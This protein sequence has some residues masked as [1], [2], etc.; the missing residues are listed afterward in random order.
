MKT[1]V[2]AGITAVLL[3]TSAAWPRRPALPGDQF[4][5]A[6]ADAVMVQQQ[7]APNT[8]AVVQPQLAAGKSIMAPVT[9][10]EGWM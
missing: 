10:G 2:V 7:V 3:V 6:A 4:Q 1:I 5:L 8:G 9:K